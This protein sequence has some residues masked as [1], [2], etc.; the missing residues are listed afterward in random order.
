MVLLL[1]LSSPLF[2]ALFGLSVRWLLA[3]LTSQ[4]PAS[5]SQGR[6][7]VWVYE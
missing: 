7:F 3:C 6:S 1:P 4:Q 5:V 2:C